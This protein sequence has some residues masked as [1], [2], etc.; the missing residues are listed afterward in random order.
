MVRLVSPVGVIVEIHVRG[1]A[2]QCRRGPNPFTPPERLLTWPR[3]SEVV[4]KAKDP[5]MKQILVRYRT[6]PESADGNE[7]LIKAVYDELGEKAPQGIRYLTLRQ[8]NGTFVHVF[9]AEEGA[10]AMMEFASFRAFQDGI[11]KRCIEPPDATDVTIVGDYR[12][13][14]A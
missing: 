13:L 4:T 2:A 7:K 3:I 14:G 10:P 1:L 9:T 6:K 12:M 8:G 11:R 5:A